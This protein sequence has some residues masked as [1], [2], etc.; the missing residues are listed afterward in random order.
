MA[1]LGHSPE[2]LNDALDK[3]VARN[4]LDQRC[5]ICAEDEWDGAEPTFLR[6]PDARGRFMSSGEGIAVLPLACTNCGYLRF[7]STTILHHHASR[8]SQ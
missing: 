6:T 5:P 1:S 4:G 7:H 3:A 2:E 8:R